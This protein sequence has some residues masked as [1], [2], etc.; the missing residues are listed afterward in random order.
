RLARGHALR[1]PRDQ[2]GR[3]AAVLQGAAPGAGGVLDV[4]RCVVVDPIEEIHCCARVRRV[5]AVAGSAGKKVSRANS[6]RVMSTGVPKTVVVLMK[7]STAAS[8]AR[9]H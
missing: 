8:V 3:R 5:A 7:L 6:D 1:R 2:R 4:T 9:R